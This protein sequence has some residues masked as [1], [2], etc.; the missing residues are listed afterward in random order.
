MSRAPDGDEPPSPDALVQDDVHSQPRAYPDEPGDVVSS[1]STSGAAPD[2]DEPR[3]DHAG[4]PPL[5]KQDRPADVTVELTDRPET[6]VRDVEPGPETSDQE[7]SHPQRDRAVAPGESGWYKSSSR[8]PSSNEPPGYERANYE[9]ANYEPANYQ[10]QADP[11]TGEYGTGDVPIMPVEGGWDAVRRRHRRQT[12]TF[13]AGLLVVLAVGSVGWLTY[14]GVVPWP[15]GGKV[16]TSQSICTRSKPELPQEITLRVYNGSNRRGLAASVSA[17]LKAY[18]FNVQETGN[19][20][21]EAK[22]RTP[23]ELRHGSSGKLAALT[24]RAY[25][26]GKV[27]DVRDDRQADTVDVVLGPSF[28][29][30]HTR[31]EANGALAALAG[32]LPLT[33][34][35]GV[36]PSPSVSRSR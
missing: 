2:A 10:A 14:S 6:T 24:I 33:C 31:R 12:L 3:V 17:Q 36:T 15:F 20:P 18:G 25:L 21:L 13:L 27:H 4:E 1:A 16:N 32:S 30:V 23:I 26:A 5:Q 22:L 9:P 35:A 8:E 11:S 28:T 34:P 29:G 19:D 7:D